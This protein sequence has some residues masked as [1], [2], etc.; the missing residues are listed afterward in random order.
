VAASTHAAH[1]QQRGEGGG[2]D[3]G[4]IGQVA[5]LRRSLLQPVLQ[6]PLDLAGLPLPNG[7]EP[8]AGGDEPCQ[9]LAQVGQNGAL[10]VQR[11]QGSAQP[12][13]GA[14]VLVAV[15]CRGRVVLE[16]GEQERMGGE[17]V[18][19]PEKAG[20]E[21]VRG[22]PALA[23][24]AQRRQRPAERLPLAAKLAGLCRRPPKAIAPPAEVRLQRAGLGQPL[25]AEGCQPSRLDIPFLHQRF[26][27]KGMRRRSNREGAVGDMQQAEKCASLLG[28]GT[29]QW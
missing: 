13:G 7:H 28:H 14:I 9:R 8:L 23:G 16:G 5:A 11:Q 19:Q 2:Q 10:F 6:L 3:P 20:A 25:A 27:P 29:E 26:Q 12:K 21:G 4:L 22:R 1:I 18:E 15:G 24:R 17:I